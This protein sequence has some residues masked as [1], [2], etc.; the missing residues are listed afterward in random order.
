MSETGI[1]TSV[2]K[3][4]NVAKDAN[5]TYV[6]SQARPEGVPQDVTALAQDDLAQAQGYGPLLNC[7]VTHN[8]GG[9]REAV[10]GLPSNLQTSPHN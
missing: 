10:R 6:S 4:A 8:D 2:L 7:S 3:G 5:G 1:T 9:G